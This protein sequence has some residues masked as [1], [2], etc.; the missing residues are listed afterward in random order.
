MGKLNSI[1]YIEYIMFK[2]LIISSHLPTFG[3]LVQ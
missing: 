1:K 2:D 3:L